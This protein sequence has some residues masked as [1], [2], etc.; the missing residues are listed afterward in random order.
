[1]SK[2]LKEFIGSLP[3]QKADAKAFCA[4]PVGYLDKHG[5]ATDGLPA[6]TTPLNP[7]AL[8]GLRL[9][10]ELRALLQ[11][12][13]VKPKESSAPPSPQEGA[14]K[15]QH[16]PDSGAAQPVFRPPVAAPQML[17]GA[18][19]ATPV[20]SFASGQEAESTQTTS[21]LPFPEFADAFA[22]RDSFRMSARRTES[23]AQEVPKAGLKPC[24]E[25]LPDASS[26]GPMVL[27]QI[28]GA[29]P[30]SDGDMTAEAVILADDRV[31]VLDS[32]ATPFS[33]LCRLEITASNGT[34]WLGTGWFISPSVIVTAGHC[35][36]LHNH[37]GWVRSITVFV[38]QNQ[39][40]Y[41]RAFTV[42]H[43]A[44]TSGWV[45]NRDTVHDYGVIFAPP[46]DQGF[47][48][49]GVLPDVTLSGALANISGY[50]QDKP[51]GTLWGHAKRLQPP[52]PAILQYEIDTFGGMSGAPVVMWDG[53]DYIATGIH[54]YGGSQLNTASRLTE[55]VF[56]NFE[57]WKSLGGRN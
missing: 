47:F 5:Y 21:G 26:A 30:T 27:R 32:S 40:H 51:S 52:Q 33:W 13:A 44:S 2:K 39:T 43:Y 50:P 53:Q 28:V 29:P 12:S 57:R 20:E 18:G 19:P 41:D 15:T 37:G 1:M 46:G 42:M 16:K 48:G 9:V 45:N 24:S 7:K 17:T 25:P 23:A 49:Y 56:Y 14:P 54:N 4:D 55:Q 22:A 10:R 34:R 38:G 6:A 36:F 35:V 31:Q 11:E 3:L 8:E